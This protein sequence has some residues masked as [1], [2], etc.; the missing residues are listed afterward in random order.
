[1]DLIALR[2]AFFTGVGFFAFFATGFFFATGLVATGL[3]AFLPSSANG[4]EGRLGSD[5]PSAA[6]FFAAGFFAAG[7]AVVFLSAGFFV[8]GAFFGA[9]V[10]RLDRA[11]FT[12]IVRVECAGVTTEARRRGTARGG[13]GAMV[14][15]EW[16]VLVCVIVL[17]GVI[18]CIWCA[19]RGMGADWSDMWS[20]TRARARAV[21]RSWAVCVG[22]MVRSRERWWRRTDRRRAGRID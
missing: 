16:G 11:A 4:L 20:S 6:A 21:G 12:C 22:G 13:E 10:A 19:R 3:V 15:F 18:I 14:F 1:M 5:G 17:L 8:A 7:F 2:T 9:G